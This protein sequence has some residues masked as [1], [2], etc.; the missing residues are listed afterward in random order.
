M[1]YLNISQQAYGLH[2]TDDEYYDDDD[3]QQQRNAA[4]G[5]AGARE[6]EAPKYK[7]EAPCLPTAGYGGLSTG[8]E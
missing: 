3:N 4:V 1:V 7:R 2:T 8:S 5:S 6:L